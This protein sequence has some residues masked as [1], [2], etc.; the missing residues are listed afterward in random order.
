MEWREGGSV[1][2]TSKKDPRAPGR[3]TS[4][5]DDAALTLACNVRCGKGI[6][7]ACNE[8]GLRAPSERVR[9]V[10]V[11]TL[12]DRVEVAARW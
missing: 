8:H 5:V 10:F 7:H 3:T 6:P 12:I 1:G 2:G 11:C 4:S 9:A